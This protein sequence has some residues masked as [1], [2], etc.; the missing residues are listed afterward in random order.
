MAAG[1]ARCRV[2]PDQKYSESERHQN[3]VREDPIHGERGDRD[4]PLVFGKVTHLV[5]VASAQD[6][7]MAGPADIGIVVGALHIAVKAV[8]QRVLVE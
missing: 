2:G 3:D 7:P 8:E 5:D 1:D 4:I 6:H